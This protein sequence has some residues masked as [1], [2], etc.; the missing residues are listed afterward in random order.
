MRT[1]FS[2][3]ITPA[4]SIAILL[5]FAVDSARSQQ[6]NLNRMLDAVDSSAGW[7][8]TPVSDEQAPVARPPIA[9][10]QALNPASQQFMHHNN[11]PISNPGRIVQQGSYPTPMWT[12][13]QA[14]Q[15]QQIQRQQ[16]AIP[17]VSR[18]IMKSFFNGNFAGA[19]GGGPAPRST[20][21]PQKSYGSSTA[22]SDWQRAEN[23]AIRAR[24]YG[25]T[26]RY[27]KDKWARK[28]AADRANYAAD[29]ARAASDRVY[30]ASLNGDPQA[31]QY[32]SQARAASDRA[33]ADANRARYN[34]DTIR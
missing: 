27:D 7:A 17:N 34:A 11:G 1:A 16:A 31:K 25:R 21:P 18:Q 24:N 30:S 33:R 15:M 2:I 8:R 19:M 23:E 29:A 28:N 32:A 10:P 9:N 22:Y 14:A 5:L 6:P 4:I 20:P 3:R 13:N 12:E 26:A